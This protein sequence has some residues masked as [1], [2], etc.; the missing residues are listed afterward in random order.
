MSWVAGFFIV[1]DR[2]LLQLCIFLSRETELAPDI[3]IPG[4]E[5]QVISEGFNVDDL[6]NAPLNFERGKL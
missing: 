2:F 1:E 3:K 4:A 5:A 6:V